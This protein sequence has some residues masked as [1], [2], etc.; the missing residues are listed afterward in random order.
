MI[1]SMCLCMRAYM[2]A[3]LHIFMDTNMHVCTCVCTYVHA[4]ITRVP[5]VYVLTYDIQTRVGQ[6]T[7]RMYSD[8]CSEQA[9]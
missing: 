1:K 2:R 7:G 4:Y 6:Q 3:C 9:Q 8:F 5:A